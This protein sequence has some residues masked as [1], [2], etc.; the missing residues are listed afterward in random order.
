ML[1]IVY[2]VYKMK[3][4]PATDEARVSFH[5]KLMTDGESTIK[6]PKSSCDDENYEFPDNMEKAASASRYQS[7]PG[8]IMQSNPAYGIAQSADPIYENANPHFR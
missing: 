6:L 3:K 2:I 5:N 7:N 1:V 8:T 4:K